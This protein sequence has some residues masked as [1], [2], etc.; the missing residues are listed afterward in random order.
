MLRAVV[1]EAATLASI[2]VR[3]H[4]RRLGPGP[5]GALIHFGVPPPRCVPRRG[6][7]PAGVRKVVR[8]ANAGRRILV[9]R[10]IAHARTIGFHSNRPV[11]NALDTVIAVAADLAFR[12]LARALVLFAAGRRAD[13]CAPGRACEGRPA[14]GA[15]AHRHRQHVRRAGVLRKDGRFRHPADHRLL[16]LPI[17]FADTDTVR[18]APNAQ[19]SALPRWCCCARP[20]K[21]ATAA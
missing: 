8:A 10:R 20:T 14:A 7:T 18:R 19:P 6:L 9:D 13:D 16:R 15:R 12:A 11:L 21:A 2:T 1:Q 5:R 4:G 3:R 17:D